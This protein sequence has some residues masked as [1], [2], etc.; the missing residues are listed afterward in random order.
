VLSVFDQQMKMMYSH[1]SSSHK[2]KVTIFM[3]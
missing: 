3:R 1:Y 2:L